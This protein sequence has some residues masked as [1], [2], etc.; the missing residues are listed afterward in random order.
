MKLNVKEIAKFGMLG[1]IIYAQ[2]AVLAALPNIHLTAV[3][4]V[5]LAVVYRLK[6]L[7]PL[8][9][10]VFLEGLFGGFTIWWIP[11]LYI[12][13]TLWGAV[14]LLPKDLPDKKYGVIIYMVICSLHGFL[15]GALFAPLQAIMFGMNFEEMI[16]WIIAGLSFDTIHGI[17]NFCLGFLVVPLIRLFRKLEKVP[18][19]NL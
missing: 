17:S 9:V 2:K 15:F 5:T 11:Y 8:Y 16:A 4:I 14:M 3:L 18:E 6:A 10:Y 19:G 1:A 12:W 13:T 7:Y